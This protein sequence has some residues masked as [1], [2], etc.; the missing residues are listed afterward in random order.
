MPTIA[1]ATLVRSAAEQEVLDAGQGGIEVALG[2][3]EAPK[4]PHG[5]RRGH[6]EGANGLEAHPRFVQHAPAL[7]LVGDA[8]YGWVEGYEPEER[9]AQV[10]A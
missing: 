6:S 1:E 4:P 5:D 3:L 9:P 2:L 7:A 8:L 10:D